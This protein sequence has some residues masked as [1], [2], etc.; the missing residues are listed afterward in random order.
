MV[1][2]AE[3]IVHLGHGRGQGEGSPHGGA[4]REPRQVPAG[5]LAE[6]ARTDVFAKESAQQVEVD[7]HHRADLP[8]A[9]RS[10]HR[11]PSEGGGQVPEEPGAAQA[12]SADHDTVAPGGRHHGQRVGGFPQIAVAEDWDGGDRLLE[13][14]DGVPVG[15]ARVEL[16]GRPG[17]QGDRGHPLAFSNTSGLEVGDVVG[18]D[19]DPHLHGHRHRPSVGD[20][21][22]DD[23]PE[24]RP[25]HGQGGTG[26]LAGDLAGRAAEVDVD[27]V[28]A[29]LFDEPDDGLAHDGR[30][31]AGQLDAPDG[32]VLAERGHADGLGVAFDQRPGG[33]HL[34]DVEPGAIAAA[35]RAKGAVG[36][37]GHGGQHDGQVYLEVADGE[38][39][40]DRADGDGIHGNRDGGGGVHGHQAA[41]RHRSVIPTSSWASRVRSVGS[42]S[43]I[44]FP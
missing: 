32:L 28:D 13:E 7:P 24:E 30:V 36:H 12:A 14:S 5:V 43:P 2:P 34:A 11:L 19:P 25:V 42:D 3:E 16:F 18:I 22:P 38:A 31:D 40:G 1:E 9:R 6:L 15:G 17:M 37:P 8:Q 41:S 29:E 26:P 21:R 27:V 4:D 44:T 35:Q 20:R 23:V 39:R 10:R 33:D